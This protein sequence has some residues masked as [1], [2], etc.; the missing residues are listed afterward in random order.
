MIFGAD[1]LIIRPEKFF[2][3]PFSIRQNSCRGRI[4]H[5]FTS[6]LNALVGG[7]HPTFCLLARI[8]VY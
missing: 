3:L 1:N 4:T 7:T 2:R 6:Y 8:V 5:Q